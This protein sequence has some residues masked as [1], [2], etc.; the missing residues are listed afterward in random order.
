MGRWCGIMLSYHMHKPLI[1]TQMSK[2]KNGRDADAGRTASSFSRSTSSSISPRDLNSKRQ[3]QNQHAAQHQP[4]SFNTREN[5]TPEVRNLLTMYGVCI[6]YNAL[7]TNTCNHKGKCK[8]AHWCCMELQGDREGFQL[9]DRVSLTLDQANEYVAKKKEEERLVTEKNR[10]ELLEKLKLKRSALEDNKSTRANRS[11][12][13][14]QLLNGNTTVYGL[15][16]T[17]VGPGEM[18]KFDPN[19]EHPSAKII[20]TKML[21]HLYKRFC[22]QRE[23]RNECMY[24]TCAGGPHPLFRRVRCEVLC[25]R[26]LLK[27]YCCHDCMKVHSD[28]HL[29]E[30]KLHSGYIQDYDEEHA[31]AKRRNTSLSKSLTAQIK[32]AEH[33]AKEAKDVKDAEIIAKTNEAKQVDAKFKDKNNKITKMAIETVALIEVLEWMSNKFEAIMNTDPDVDAIGTLDDD[34]ESEDNDNRVPSPSLSVQYRAVRDWQ[35]AGEVV[36]KAC[37]RAK[38]SVEA[39]E[40]RS[41]EAQSDESA[42]LA[43]ETLEEPTIA[44]AGSEAAVQE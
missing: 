7:T 26:C 22:D 9:N 36:A 21:D 20:K 25:P 18:K 27:A 13:Q 6:H 35:A 38:Q 10:L 14:A 17:Q 37:A 24:G 1:H 32:K 3:R 15:M 34:D 28:L 2:W 39:A 40:A 29:W 44:T 31:E 30:C 23:I 19:N 33:M 11:S 12:Y 8:A 41:A 42:M 16:F 43:N 4:V 5:M